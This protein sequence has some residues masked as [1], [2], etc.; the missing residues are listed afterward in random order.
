MSPEGRSV[1]WVEV[2]R[3]SGVKVGIEPADGRC[4]L[5]QARNAALGSAAAK[6]HSM[7][8]ADYAQSGQEVADDG[9]LQH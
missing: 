8:S 7:S 3:R 2:D 9:C 1:G 5:A 4:V 6:I